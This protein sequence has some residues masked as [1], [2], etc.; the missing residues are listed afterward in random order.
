LLEELDHGLHY[1][2]G[3]QHANTNGSDGEILRQ[4]LH[5]VAHDFRGHG[6]DVGHAVSRLNR[7]R[8]DAAEAITVMCRQGLDIGS[9]AGAGGGVKAGNAEHDRLSRGHSAQM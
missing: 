9:D 4:L 8:R 2:P 3:A 5:G 1:F 7:K 6:L